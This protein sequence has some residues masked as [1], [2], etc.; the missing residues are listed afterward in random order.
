LEEGVDM[1]AD[2]LAAASRT[3]EWAKGAFEDEIERNPLVSVAI[4]LG[5]GFVMGFLSRGSRAVA[6][7]PPRRQVTRR[8]ARAR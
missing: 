5:L 2:A 6:A 1:G 4:A 3:T 8:P 7:K